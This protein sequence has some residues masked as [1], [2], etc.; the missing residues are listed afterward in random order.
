MPGRPLACS[1]VPARPRRGIHSGQAEKRAAADPGRNLAGI[2]CVFSFEPSQGDGNHTN[3][4]RG[5]DM[6]KVPGGRWAGLV[7]VLLVAAAAPARAD[8]E[9]EFTF[10][11]GEL[12]VANLLGKA[13]I[14]GYNGS[15]FRVRVVVQ[16]ADA[17]E[18]RLQ[19]DE[20]RGRRSELAIQFP[21]DETRRYVYPPM[22]HRSRTRLSLDRDRGGWLGELMSLGRG[23]IEVRG[24]DFRDALELW[25][26]LY[27]DVPKGSDV[28]VLLGVGSL[29]GSDVEGNVDLATQTGGA[30]VQRV[31][32]KVRVDTG[33]G[34][35]GANDITGPLDIDT[36]SGSVRVS[37]VTDGG[38]LRIDTGSG[39]VGVEEVKANELV[40]D[41]GSGSVEVDG[42]AVEVLSVDTGSGGVDAYE[43]SCDRVQIDTGSGGVHLELLRMGRGRYDIDTG[44]G[45]IRLH[46]PHDVSAE[47]DVQTGS[48]GLNVEIEGV[49]LSRR[50]RHDGDARFTVGD[51]DS[52][53]HLETGSGTIRIVQGRKG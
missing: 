22:G 16:G 13:E 40:I 46:V 36:G 42:A 32:G 12:R 34:S 24:E 44:S 1:G 38:R 23:R 50:E 48:G 52:R 31:R 21:L 17:T 15:E 10:P 45:G 35:V 2:G 3:T 4:N 18:A 26:D 5:G 14:R 39:S 7:T 47:F 27:I 19:F 43:I 8:F 41:T 25:A 37:R 9:K 11:A 20:K 51:G 53:V 30:D 49:Q 6:R 28:A 29:D 33:S